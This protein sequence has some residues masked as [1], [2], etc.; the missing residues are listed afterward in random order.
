M[1]LPGR[2]AMCRDN[3]QLDFDDKMTKFGKNTIIERARLQTT[4]AKLKTESYMKGELNFFY[5]C[6]Y[7]KYISI[8]TK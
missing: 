2:I 6:C 7:P 3:K 5:C 8:H 1:K 4:R